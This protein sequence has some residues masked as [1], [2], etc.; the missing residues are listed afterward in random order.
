MEDVGLIR[1]EVDDSD[2]RVVRIHLTAKGKLKRDLSKGSVI[3]FNQAVQE[4]LT[5]KELRDFRA[6][7]N[8]IN[9]ILDDKQ[10]F[11]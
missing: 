3:R 7:M 10:L 11:V 5:E 6:A 9:A 1:R 4:R 2:K 8:T